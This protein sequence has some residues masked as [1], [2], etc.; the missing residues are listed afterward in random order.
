MLSFAR[1]FASLQVLFAALLLVF[2]S[3]AGL[4]HSKILSFRQSQSPPPGPSQDPQAVAVLQQSYKAMGGTVPSDSI[5]TGNLEVV[6]GTEDSKGTVRILTK[7]TSESFLQLT[8]PDGV[9][10]TVYAYGQANEL[11]NSTVTI[12]VLELA[13]TSQAPDF[14]LPLIANLLN[15]P[16]TSCQY[17]GLESLN[18]VSL[19]HIRTWDSFASQP[20]LQGL[21]GFS[22]RDFWIDAS[23]GLLQ[24]I[25][26]TQHPGSGAIV[27]VS[28]DVFFSNYQASSGVSYPYTIQKSLNGTPWATITIQSVSFNNGLTDSNFPVQ[29]GS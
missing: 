25:S 27:G 24:R 4:A 29:I 8:M 12:S 19:Q 3:Q 22:T 17:I 21:V 23:T 15:D 13:V 20:A 2:T 1:P 6:A 26:Y 7:G 10:T 9:R 11:N 16:D 14:P 18:G 28:V 5:A